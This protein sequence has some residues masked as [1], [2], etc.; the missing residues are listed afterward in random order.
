MGSDLQQAIDRWPGS[1][2]HKSHP[3]SGVGEFAEGEGVA[4]ALFVSSKEC[5][6]DWRLAPLLHSAD[7]GKRAATVQ[8]LPSGVAIAGPIRQQRLLVTDVSSMSIALR[9]S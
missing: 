6:E 9:S 3:Y 4:V 7:V 5:T 1:P 8:G 2:T